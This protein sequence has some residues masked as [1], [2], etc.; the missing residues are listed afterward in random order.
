[1]LSEEEELAEFRA[2]KRA[3]DKSG[4]DEAFYQ[5]EQALV[6][7][8]GRQFHALMPSRAFLVLAEALMALKK[9]VM[10]E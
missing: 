10:D 5:L 4:F 9:R 6:N 8:A 7:P 2:W 1:M 3:K